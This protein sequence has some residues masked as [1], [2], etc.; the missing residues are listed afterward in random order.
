MHPSPRIFSL[1]IVG[2]ILLLFPTS[3]ALAYGD[4][5]I[6]NE[7]L[8]LSDTTVVHLQ[9]VKIYATATNN[10]NNDLLGSVQFKNTTTGNP[11]GSD[12]PISVLAGSTDSV[13][14]EWRPGA[15]TY[16][17][18]A[19]VIPWDTAGDDAGNNT[20]SRTLTVDYDFDNDGIGNAQ[21]PDDDND[22]TPDVDDDY[23]L[24]PNE[25]QDTDKDGIGNAQDPDDDNDGT[26]DDEDQMPTDA[27]EILDTDSDGIGNNSDIDDDNDGL[28]DET[29]LASVS[30]GGTGTD[31]QNSDTDGDNV[32]DGEDE[33]PT[34]EKEW[35]DSDSDG[36]GNNA[37]KDDDNDGLPDL[38]DEFPLNKGPVIILEQY[39]EEAP[40]KT[41]ERFNVWNASLSYDEDGNLTAYRWFTRDGRLIGEEAILKLKIGSNSFLP[42]S[43]MV[44]D[45]L[46]ETRTLDLSKKTNRTLGSMGLGLL[47]ALLI[48]L[49]LILYLK[50]TSTAPK[51]VEPVKQVKSKS[52]SKKPRKK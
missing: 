11:I 40:E 51:K 32:V 34:D 35:I 42:A 15:G 16:T 13:F 23:P 24:D 49:A 21:D 38:E 31:P 36:T 50:Y 45:D 25:S 48:A 46:G 26:L 19:T 39:E 27:S 33:F 41:G 6:K 28:S 30:N 1:L 3:L 17:I 22:G 8:I 44:F 20:A 2:T 5:Q 7:N 14:V 29:E 12:Q 47:I 10:S 4:I 18:A 43:L 52:S 37:D 9:T